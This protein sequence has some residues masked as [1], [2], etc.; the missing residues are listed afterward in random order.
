MQSTCLSNYIMYK[1]MDLIGQFLKIANKIEKIF[2]F[3]SFHL[4]FNHPVGLFNMRV[5]H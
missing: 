3:L 4:T 5:T 2:A 1:T